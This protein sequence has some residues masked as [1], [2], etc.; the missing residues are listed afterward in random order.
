V[1]TLLANGSLALEFF[2]GTATREEGELHGVPKRARVA[3]AKTSN[4][5]ARPV[6][7]LFIIVHFLS[8]FTA[9]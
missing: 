5:A 3:K 6:K 2:G 8:N 7:H 4:T 1:C 9:E